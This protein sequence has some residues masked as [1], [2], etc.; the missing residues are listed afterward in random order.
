MLAVL[1]DDSLDRLHLS[2][3]AKCFGGVEAGLKP[4]NV[5]YWAAAEGLLSTLVRP[6]RLLTEAR[7]RRKLHLDAL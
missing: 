5:R 4:P 3:L 2:I 6:V 7:S 1:A